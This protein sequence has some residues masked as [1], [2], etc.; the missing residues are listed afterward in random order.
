[1]TYTVYFSKKRDF[2][3]FPSSFLKQTDDED[4]QCEEEQPEMKGNSW[5][6]SFLRKKDPLFWAAQ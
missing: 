5:T 1:M 4:Q 3:P 6:D 2:K